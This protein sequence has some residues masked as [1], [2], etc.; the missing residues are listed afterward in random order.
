MSVVGGR[1]WRS[2]GQRPDGVGDPAQPDGVGRLEQHHVAGPQV[3]GQPGGGGVGVRHEDRL[4]APG[5]FQARRR[6]AAAGPPPRPRG[7]GGC[8]AARRAGP[9]RRAPTWAVGP[10][11]RISP[12][13]ATV[14]DPGGRGRSRPA[15]AGRPASSPGWRCRRRRRRSRRRRARA[16]PSGRA[17]SRS[18]RPERPGDRVQVQA[19]RRARRR[20]PRRRCRRGARPPGAWT[21]ARPGRRRA[22]RSGAGRGRRRPGRRS[23][24]RRRGRSRRCVPVRGCGR[25]SPRT[26]A[27]SALSTATPASAEGVDDLALGLRDG[28]LRA[29]LPEVRLAHVE[30]QGDVRWRD[31]AGGAQ[32]ADVAGPHL[33]DQEV[34]AG[35]GAQHGERQAELVVEGPERR[36][37]GAAGGQHLGEQVLGARL[38]LRAGEGD[39]AQRACRVASAGGPASGPPGR[40]ARP[41]RAGP[42]PRATTGSATTHAGA[43][44]VAGRQDGGRAGRDGGGGVVVPV[45]PL[46]RRRPRRARRA[47]R[48]GCPGTRRR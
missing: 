29:E 48:S 45:D 13:T 41:G 27:S 30:D 44:G 28:L 46:A 24:R 6:G 33:Q 36:H 20:P 3:L 1:R 7:A 2:A 25:P 16:P 9:R 35:P 32:V 43:A 17:T 19:Q 34:G 5:A 15:P 8:R 18:R 37:G 11:S 22:A 10:S 26:S 14:R 23:G 12:R 47:R 42:G 31:R 4:L 40:A 38:A 21:P 39:D